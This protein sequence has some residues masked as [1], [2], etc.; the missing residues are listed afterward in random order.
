MGGFVGKILDKGAK[1]YIRNDRRLNEQVYTDLISKY[2]HD[3]V[4]IVDG[5]EYIT[6]GVFCVNL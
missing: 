2:G 6:E 3:K 1:V 4:K 5:K